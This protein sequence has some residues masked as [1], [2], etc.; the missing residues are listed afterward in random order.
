MIR[1]FIAMAAVAASFAAAPAAA[2]SIDFEL[3]LAGSSASITDQGGGGFV[4]LI[5][6][7]GI[8]AGLSSGFGAPLHFSL[9]QGE[10]RAI[11]FID[12]D[13]DGTTGF[14]PRKF[15]IFATLALKT[16]SV[17][18]S[19][20]GTGLAWF[21]GGSIDLDAGAGGL[22]WTSGVPNTVTLS[23]GSVVTIDFEEGARL[24]AGAPVTTRAFV[25]ADYVAPVPLPAAG[26]LLIAGLGGLAA[27][28][29]RRRP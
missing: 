19:A 2:K 15:D 25:T 5:T 18:T 22:D 20:G 24:F 6:R 13:L 11:D 16:P 7:C 8:E 3:D 12:F 1:K 29:T 27:V 23:N 4:C 17:S 14:F 9:M 21:L 10:T 28:R 26:F